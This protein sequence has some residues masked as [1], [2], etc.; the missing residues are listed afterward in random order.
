MRRKLG[1]HALLQVFL[2]AFSTSLPAQTLL[3]PLLE[4]NTYV[5]GLSQPTSIVFLPFEDGQPVE[6][7]VCEKGTGRVIHVRDGVIQATA[8]DLHVNSGSERGLLGIALHPDFA[9]NRFVYLLH[10]QQ[11]CI[12]HAVF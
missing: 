7:L 6:L 4:V 8:L 10:V 2:L 9:V 3:D 1:P 12:R 5:S 11:H